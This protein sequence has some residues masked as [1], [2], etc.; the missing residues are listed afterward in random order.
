MTTNN[1]FNHLLEV[2]KGELSLKNRGLNND[3]DYWMSKINNALLEREVS[4]K[5]YDKMVLED[6]KRKLNNIVK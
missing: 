1:Q 2:L 3:V 4:F 6:W 5:A